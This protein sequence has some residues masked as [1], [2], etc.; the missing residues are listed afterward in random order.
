MKKRII[1][2]L[3]GIA[4]IALV[5]V[6]ASVLFLGQ[7]VKN[8][9]ETVGPAVTQVDV[10][11]SGAS[12]W[13]VT[14]RASLGGLFIGNPAGYKTD[15]ALKAVEISICLEPASVL[16]DKIIIDSI[17][18]KSPEITVEGGLQNNNLTKIQANVN[19]F[20]SHHSGAPSAGSTSSSRKLQVN[21]LLITD[22]RL[23]YKILISADQTVT[24]PLPDIHLQN[25]GQGKDGITAPEIIQK[26]LTTL[27]E[28]V[29]L[30]VAGDVGK[31]GKGVLSG[32]KNGTER[33]KGFI[34]N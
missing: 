22:A 14:S 17:E 33:L 32:V 18:I 15:S 27:V 34:G 31:A 4:V 12:V 20:V 26:T 6:I 5:A 10:K 3:V 2:I 23:H 9:V 30:A 8:A 29:P 1:R 21:N 11:L 25:L 24:I 13:L 28:S 7:I 19:D 16:S